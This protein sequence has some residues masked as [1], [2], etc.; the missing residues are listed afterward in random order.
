MI[1]FASQFEEIWSSMAR[2]AWQHAAPWYQKH[3]GGALHILYYLKIFIIFK[4]VYKCRFSCI[5]EKGV[6]CLE[7]GRE[8]IIIHL[9]WVLGTEFRSYTRTIQGLKH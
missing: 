7:T 4:C 5:S 8:A 9:A 2:K 3:V 6:R 1:Y